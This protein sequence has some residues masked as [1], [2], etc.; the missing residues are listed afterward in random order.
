MGYAG[1]NVQIF[2]KKINT[3]GQTVWKSELPSS[4]AVATFKLHA[5][6][7]LTYGLDYYLDYGTYYGNTSF[8]NIF[9]R[10]LIN[11]SDIPQKD[12]NTIS[13]RIYVDRNKNSSFDSLLDR[14]LYGNIVYAMPGH[15]Y[16]S[17]D[18]NGNYTIRVPEGNYQVYQLPKTG[19]MVTDIQVFPEKNGYYEIEFYGSDSTVTGKDFIKDKS[20]THQLEIDVVSGI[21]KLCS[22]NTTIVHYINHGESAAENSE[23]RIIY[24]SAIIPL[25]SD[26]PFIKMDSLLIFSVGN[27]PGGGT[28]SIYIKDST[29]CVT[30]Q[31]RFTQC[32]K[33][34]ISPAS[35]GKDNS[36]WDK[37]EIAINIRCKEEYSRITIRNSGFSM[38]D[39]AEYRIYLNEVLD[40]VAK[41]KLLENESIALNVKTFGKTIRVEADLSS[42]HP[43]KHQEF[44]VKEGCGTSA[45]STIKGIPN[46]FTNYDE[47]PE[48]ENFCS[49]IDEL[50][51]AGTK[52]VLPVG[53]TDKHFIPVDT[54]LEFFLR[55][56]LALAGTDS[57]LVITDELSDKLDLSTLAVGVVSHETVW[58]ITG[59]GFPQLIFNVNA[60]KSNG[61]DLRGDEI[62]VSFRIKPKKEL[63]SGTV[64]P[65][66]AYTD[67]PDIYTFAQ[68][69]NTIGMPAASPS[70]EYTPQDCGKTADLK[71]S[72]T[73][74]E[75]LCD[76]TAH[77][78]RVESTGAD[79]VWQ[80]SGSA[81]LINKYS[82]E[83]DIQGIPS[84]E[85]IYLA[86]LTY[87]DQREDV[88]FRVISSKTPEVPVV[89]GDLKHC[90]DELT[91][92][93]TATGS[94]LIWYEEGKEVFRGN[95]F[96]PDLRSAN[97][98]VTSSVNNCKSLPASFFLQI[99]QK[100]EIPQFADFKQCNTSDWKLSATGE[101]IVWYR[102]PEL[103]L[104]YGEGPEISGNSEESD[105][106]EFYVT[107]LVEGCIS[108]PGLA[109][110]NVYKFTSNLFPVTNI[111]T[112]NNDGFNDVFEIQ[113]FPERVCLGNFKD[114]EIYNRQGRSVFKSTTED[115]RWDGQDL[116][117]SVYFVTIRYD[118]FI[119]KGPLSILR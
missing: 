30:S 32:I 1:E 34:S 23:I 112:P 45:D 118:N 60:A 82:G 104:N 105:T 117:N 73:T 110:V 27:I 9:K 41:Y 55:Y 80:T 74:P 15:Y 94:N 93:I 43:Y 65:N 66:Y 95:Y 85:S 47:T 25:K 20:A 83:T 33:A 89:A 19:R 12:L 70:G 44:F 81:N 11:F 119:Y 52:E 29:V 113:D 37:S 69:F 56:P 14:P 21:R 87:C 64:V 86:T 62:F 67:N 102:N 5:Y 76:K 107:Q 39:S 10:L 108:L 35:A 59:L 54:Y 13:G 75:F 50:P 17:A 99:I 92:E 98:S 111:I 109:T 114:I 115:F 2:L 96:V 101:G 51:S 71:Q 26:K 38:G 91:T 90:S 24:P 79:V 22:S 16:A 46:R 97:Y 58:R 28:G 3:T 7:D 48:Y 68:T 88:L 49:V 18:K 31:Q 4:K 116:S 8:L 53:I 42:S 63:A 78:L 84:G 6:R 57:V 36:G 100:P 103:T 61:V 40:Y 106:L 72:E 77:K